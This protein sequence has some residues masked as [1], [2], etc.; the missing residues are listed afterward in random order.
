MIFSRFGGP[1]IKARK[2]QKKPKNKFPVPL[3]GTEWAKTVVI[4]KMIDLKDSQSYLKRITCIQI[5]NNFLDLN[6]L[7]IDEILNIIMELS[8]DS[9]PNVRFNCAKTLV[10][11]KV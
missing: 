1:K 9:V 10:V 5:A 2:S 8:N 4:P 6:N 3:F 7:S 11:G